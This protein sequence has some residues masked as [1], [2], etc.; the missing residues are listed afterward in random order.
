MCKLA[1]NKTPDMQHGFYSGNNC[2]SGELLLQ[3]ILF[4]HRI[5]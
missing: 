5:T 4:E 1:V 3:Q 2:Q